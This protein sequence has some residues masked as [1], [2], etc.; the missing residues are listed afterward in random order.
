MNILHETFY[1]SVSTVMRHD[2]II[3]ILLTSKY[4]F[5][6]NILFIYAIRLI[7]NL[8]NTAIVIV[9]IKFHKK[10]SMTSIRVI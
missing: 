9:L 3:K 1:N 7:S 4:M 10:V 5:T 2:Y 8:A 6:V